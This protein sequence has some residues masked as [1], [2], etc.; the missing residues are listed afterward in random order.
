MKL[1]SAP[2]FRPCLYIIYLLICLGASNTVSASQKSFDHQDGSSYV[3]NFNTP[4]QDALGWHFQLNNSDN[5]S[6]NK[7]LSGLIGPT[8]SLRY[9]KSISSVNGLSFMAGL[10]TIQLMLIL[11]LFTSLMSLVFFSRYRFKKRLLDHVKHS[12]ELMVDKLRELES[13]NRAKQKYLTI[14]SHDLINP[15]NVMMG[16]STLLKEEYNKITDGERQKF[17]NA[18]CKQVKSNYYLVKRILNWV[19]I[20]ESQMLLRIE[21][22]QE[23]RPL[24]DDAISPHVLYAETKDI[25]I[26]NDISESGV[27][28][29]FDKNILVLTLSNLI[30]NAIKF[31][32]KGG[33][34]RVFNSFAD[35]KVFI[36]VED[37]GVGFSRDQLKN[38]FSVEER[39]STLGT[40]NE[41]GSGMGLNICK[42]LLTFHNGTIAIRSDQNNG[43][44]VTISLPVNS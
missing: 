14:I 18:I 44:T 22:I 23:I 37:N 36:S 21:P 19:N 41:T 38:A 5:S 29:Y 25:T 40:F 35:G 39:E 1:L 11:T 12:N 42:D 16:Y 33:E 32:H 20:Q 4:V 24:I 15:F 43:T 2:C 27:L 13:S 17:I 3:E 30:N 10:S 7:G 6:A 26:H 28:S 9:R 8:V 31:T 34:I